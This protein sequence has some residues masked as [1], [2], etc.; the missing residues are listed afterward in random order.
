V[1]PFVGASKVLPSS[2]DQHRAGR[3]P[4][5]RLDVSS[6]TPNVIP[7]SPITPTVPSPPSH[8]P[9]TQ[10]TESDAFCGFWLTEKDSPPFPRTDS[11]KFTMPSPKKATVN[12]SAETESNQGPRNVVHR[13]E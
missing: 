12:T 3:I 10:Q 6:A 5:L 8:Q 1:L 11:P 13:R 9:V 2:P 7:G 4:S